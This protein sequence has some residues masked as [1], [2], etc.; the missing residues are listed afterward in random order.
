MKVHD[1]RRCEFFQERVWTQWRFPKNY[2]KIG[3][4]HAHGYCRR[5]Q[6]RCTEVAGCDVPMVKGGQMV[7]ETEVQSV[8]DVR[9]IQ[10]REDM[11]GGD[12]HADG[13]VRVRGDG[14]SEGPEGR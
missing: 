10:D 3:V 1:C 5:H 7:M 9:G 4:D 12:S 6:K 2:H 8:P 13:A 11:Q 14:G